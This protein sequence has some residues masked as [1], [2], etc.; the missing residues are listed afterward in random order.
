MLIEIIYKKGTFIYRRINIQSNVHI[1]RY[2][3]RQIY[4]IHIKMKDILWDLYSRLTYI[5]NRLI[6]YRVYK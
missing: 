2:T 1:E 3:Y 5:Q 4:N 6:H